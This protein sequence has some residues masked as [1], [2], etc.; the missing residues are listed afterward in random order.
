[1]LVAPQAITCLDD[2]R[3]RWKRGHE[4]LQRFLSETQREL[5]PFGRGTV[6]V[7]G[8]LG[9]QV[10][11]RKLGHWFRVPNVRCEG[12]EASRLWIADLRLRIR[13]SEV[14]SVIPQSAI[15][16]P[17][18]K[19]SSRHVAV[20]DRAVGES[21]SY[22]VPDPYDLRHLIFQREVQLVVG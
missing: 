14:R 18:S 7:L 9:V 6:K 22:G 2:R 5:D 16:N 4:E 13:N 1:M 11:S 10:T 8:H 15:N 17:Q 12:K 21:D 3:P 19:S 20:E